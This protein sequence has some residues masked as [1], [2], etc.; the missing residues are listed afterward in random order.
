MRTLI[1]ALTVTA[2]IPI[3]VATSSTSAIAGGLPLVTGGTNLTVDASV[4]DPSASGPITMKA[5]TYNARGMTLGGADGWWDYQETEPGS[6]VHASGEITCLVVQGNHAWIGAVVTR[7]DDPAYVGLDAWWQ[8]Q[9][10]GSGAN[11]AP[12]MTT[13]VGFGDPGRAQDYCNRAPTSHFP[14][15]VQH[16]QVTVH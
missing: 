10:N 12:D 13:F 1:R 6:S 14:F 9:D 11:A 2:A 3:A 4:F 7:A 16:G 8:V 15:N 5:L